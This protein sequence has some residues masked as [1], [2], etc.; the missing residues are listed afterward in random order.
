MALPTPDAYNDAV[1]T[2][3][4]AFSDTALANAKVACNGF[5]IPRALGGGF[6]ITY[7]LSS[8]DGKSY[9]VRCFHKEVR[10]LQ[11]RYHRIHSVLNT[12]KSSLFVGFEYQPTG[13]NVKSVGY[14]IV[15][16]EWAT[17]MTLGEYIEQNHRN[18]TAIVNLRGSFSSMEAELHQLG[19]AHGDLQNGNVLVCPQG[20]VRLVDYDG[21]FVPG[22]NTG[23]GTELGH[24]NFQ[25]PHRSA[26]SFGP[27]LD[28]FS[29]L[30]VD[31]S[32]WAITL[33][34]DLFQ[35]FS[36]GENILFAANDFSDPASSQVFK[37]LKAVSDSHFQT[38]IERFSEICQSPFSAIPRLADFLGGRN[39]PT[40]P[41][42][43]Q[44]A[45]PGPQKYI[46]AFPVIDASNFS[47]VCQHVGDKVELVG[48]V[49]EVKEGR[50]RKGTPY[51]FINFGSWR[52]D[53]VRVTV[54]SEGLQALGVAP[55]SSWHG[56]WIVINGLIDPVY[57]GRNRFKT[58]SYRSVG[59]TLS[60][61]SQLH[62]ITPEE[63]LWRLNRGDRTARP[64]TKSPAPIPSRNADILRV[65]RQN[66]PASTTSMGPS[67]SNPRPQRPPAIKPYQPT[68]RQTQPATQAPS[69]Q[70]NLVKSRNE[71]IL[72]G[73]VPSGASQG[74]S[75]AG[76]GNSAKSATTPTNDNSGCVIVLIVMAAF[77]C[78]WIFRN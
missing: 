2:P 67:G 54:W 8:Q 70:P 56:Q 5:G 69:T 68:P 63:A 1:Q 73:L 35:M 77:L 17:G 58:I 47:V 59:I 78:W 45:S 30:V 37:A 12:T 11:D 6:A 75:V 23:G 51:V 66:K 7:R 25:H 50:T 10:D 26:G 48:Q 9:A 3:R 28:R 31:L 38:A 43:L 65:I 19:I 64:A 4:L 39:I 24:K 46:G 57:H 40:A 20:G 36:T 60:D 53:C 15:K 34:P 71:A 44:T 33:N 55:D 32:L 13:I 49:F 21:M 42:P 18:R 74:N 27:S 22:M 41:A 52:D 76:S 29:F 61:R 62:T 14:P 72:K 16:M